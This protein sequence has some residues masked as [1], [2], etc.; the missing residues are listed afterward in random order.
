[1]SGIAMV[2]CGLVVMLTAW[3][4]SDQLRF[5]AIIAALVS[6]RIAITEREK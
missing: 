1:M 3:Y 6:I 2:A 4:P 5:I